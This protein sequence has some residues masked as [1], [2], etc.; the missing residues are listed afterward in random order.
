M[1]MKEELMKK[2]GMMTVERAVDFILDN[3]V[4]K[5]KEQQQDERFRKLSEA[6]TNLLASEIKKLK[7]S[8]K[9]ELPRKYNGEY[10]GNNHL[11][12][13]Q[14]IDMLVDCLVWVMSKEV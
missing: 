3:Y 13:M 4:E 5:T 8:P 1:R 14:K 10:D 12:I 6:T 11:L 7:P 2:I 9:T